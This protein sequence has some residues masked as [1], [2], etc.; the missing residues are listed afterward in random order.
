MSGKGWIALHRKIQGNF[1]WKEP[2]KFSK[3]EAWIDILMEV[4]HSKKSQQVAFGMTVS[5]CNYG[6]SLK[7]IQTWAK[8]WGWSRNKVYRFFRLLEKCDMIATKS[9][10]LTTR[11]TVCNYER[12]DPKQNA[13]GTANRTQIERRQNAD[14]TQPDTDNNVN[15]ANNGK[16]DKYSP[17]SDEFRLSKLLLDLILQRKPDYKKPNLQ[18]WAVHI[19]RLIRLDKRTPEQIE[20]VIKWCQADSGDGTWAGWQ[21][22]ILSTA[23]LREKIDKLELAMEKQAGPSTAPLQIGP[24]GKTPRES[25]K[26][27]FERAEKNAG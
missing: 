3:A 24:D 11:L 1:L 15:N 5:T 14:R 17:N 13:G 21:D 18:K 19:D 2:R 10:Q 9:E 12:Y 20:A 4:Q 25:L 22:N 6:E 8:R 16:N 23:K 26:E 7:T 27:Q